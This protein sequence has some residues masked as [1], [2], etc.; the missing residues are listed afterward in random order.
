MKFRVGVDLD[1]TIVCYDHVFLSVAKQLNLLGGENRLSKAEVKERILSKP[2][3]EKVWQK[4]QGQVYGKY[5]YFASLFPGFV[6]FLCLSKLRGHTVFIVSHKT[7]YGHFDEDRVPLRKAAID[8]MH[9]NGLIGSE[10]FTFAKDEIFFEPTRESKIDRIHA[11]GLTHFIDDLR[12]VFEEP[13]FPEKTEKIL[14]DVTSTSWRAITQHLYKDWSPA[15]ICVSV[16]ERFPA[17]KVHSAELIKVQG[18]SRIFK[19]TASEVGV[20]ALKVYPD[21]QFDK[22]PRL[23]TEFSAVSFLQ[24]KNFPV[25]KAIVKDE[26]FNWAIYSWISGEGIQSPNEDFIEEASN[27]IENLAPLSRHC[28]EDEVRLRG[29][30][31]QSN[32]EMK[33]GLPRPLMRP[34]NDKFPGFKNFPLASEACLSGVEIV[35]QIQEKF[36]RLMQVESPLLEQFLNEEFLPVFQLSIQVARKYANHLFELPLP[37]SL[38]ILSPSDFG[39]HNAIREESGRTVFIDFE[40]FG[41][42]DPVKLV[43]DLYFHPGMNL[44]GELKEEWIQ[45]S[46]EIFRKDPSFET[47]LIAYLPLFGLRWC[48]ILL[49]VFLP[50]RTALDKTRTGLV[51]LN[52][53]RSLLTQV[54]KIS[55]VRPALQVS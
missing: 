5:M 24:A 31:K 26:S 3:G 16:Q 17:L 52:K 35:R 46:K 50:N 2:E 49:N 8:W 44:S 14:F 7:E 51:Q 34:R 40:Y 32:L 12:E 36:L 6:E 47:R 10:V 13:S 22:R 19:L 55:H 53:A 29:K 15:E 33:P 45:R 9:A 43:C 37:R 27:F 54:T 4:L 21:R 48:L 30:S 28:E 20:H 38:Q 39:A 11:L 18:N 42:D 23:E 41:W 25:M 1:N